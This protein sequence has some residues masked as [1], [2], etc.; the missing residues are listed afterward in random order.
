MPQFS[1][2]GSGGGGSSGP[3]KSLDFRVGFFVPRYYP[4][5][6]DIKK[7]REI[8]EQKALCEGQYVKD[9]GGKNRR[10]TAS[11][12]VLGHN[13]SQFNRLLNLGEPIEFQSMQWSGEVLVKSGNLRGPFRWDGGESAWWF[14]FDLTCISTGRDEGLNQNYGI[15][16]SAGG[17][18]AGSIGGGAGFG[19]QE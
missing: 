16:G 13:T 4:E 5:D 17:S 3:G 18:N 2:G 10:C 19:L 6:V 7:E 8:D 11:G 15:G 12:V 1:S 14:K 9:L